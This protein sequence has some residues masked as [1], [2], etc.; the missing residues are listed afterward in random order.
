MMNFKENNEGHMRDFEWRQGKEE[1]LL[2]YNLK[3]IKK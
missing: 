3:K 2:Y 1:M